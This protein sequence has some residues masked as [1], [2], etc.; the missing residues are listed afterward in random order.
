[1]WWA[2]N[3]MKES[4]WAAA[5]FR[6]ARDQRGQHYHRRPAR[7]GRQM[8]AHLVAMLDHQHHLPPH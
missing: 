1:M 2:F 7:T 4:P 3:S 5:A 8:D 6:Q